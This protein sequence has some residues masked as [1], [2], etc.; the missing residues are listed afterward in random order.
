MKYLFIM[1]LSFSNSIAWAI[2]DDGIFD[3]G[4]GGDLVICTQSE[5]KRKL[6][7]LDLYEQERSGFSPAKF[8]TDLYYLDLV[9]E[10]ISRIGRRLPKIATALNFEFQRLKE[11][12]H[13]VSDEQVPQ[14]HDEYHYSIADNCILRQLAVQ[15]GNGSLHGR[16]YL[17]NSRYF[18]QLDT[19]N[20]A[21]LI[22]H[23]LVYR[24]FSL[25]YPQQRLTSRRVRQ[26][27]GFFISEEFDK[28]ATILFPDGYL[29]NND[30]V[31]AYST[32]KTFLPSV[33]K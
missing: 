27:V 4:N 2:S 16:I 15:W 25:H 8:S 7:L 31:R 6:Q 28:F 21:T 10:Q 32:E 18:L 33:S 29:I 24:L 11:N 12:I 20:R 19:Y 14:V 9:N 5:G 17:I 13:F 1:I 30:G 23:E 26:Y 3:R 22:L